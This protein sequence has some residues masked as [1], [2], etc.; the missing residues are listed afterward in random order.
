LHSADFRWGLWLFFVGRFSD[1]IFRSKLKI[2]FVKSRKPNRREKL[3]YR[4]VTLT[5]NLKRD[6]NDNKPPSE[7][8][9]VQFKK[10][11]T[12]FQLNFENFFNFIELDFVLV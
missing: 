6:K 7:V 1:Q 4:P 9:G 5:K 10:K 11:K 3:S 2:V 12:I 8:G